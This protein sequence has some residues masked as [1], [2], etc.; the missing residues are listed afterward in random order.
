M[1]STTTATEDH[2]SPSQLNH[3][4]NTVKRSYDAAFKL[5]VVAYAEQNSN[6]GAGRKFSVDE[7]R[8]R[9]WRKQKEQLVSMPDKKKRLGTPGRKVLLPDMEEELAAWIEDQR[10][11][12]LP[13]TRTAIQ[14][15]AKELHQ[16]SEEFGASRGWL[17]KFLHRY[18]FTLRRKTT[19]SQ[20]LPEC[21]ISKV[22]AFIMKTRKMIHSEHFSPSL[23]GNMDETPLWLDIP[24]DT[25]VSRVGERTVSIRSTGYDK[26]RFTVV[27]AAMADGRK[28]KPYVV[29]KGV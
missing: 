4:R 24:G 28:I 14:M 8:V 13:V 27:L 7:R 29:L 11:Q 3:S 25:T 22:V 2:H 26:A 10:S 12:H 18:G 17:E 20:S 23:I 6:R 21:Y 5:K 19:V 15:K 9:E 1:D 16:G